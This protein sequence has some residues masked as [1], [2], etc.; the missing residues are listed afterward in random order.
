[1]AK[2]RNTKDQSI[3]ISTF[4]TD[5]PPILGGLQRGDEL[6]TPLT[7]IRTPKLCNSRYG[8][9]GVYPRA[10]KSLQDQIIKL[11]AGINR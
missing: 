2:V 7:A 1:M 5:V 4:K 10:S 9:R 6:T 11:N 8:V 3:V